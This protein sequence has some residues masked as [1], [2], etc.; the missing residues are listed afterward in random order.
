MCSR[1]CLIILLVARVNATSVASTAA[2]PSQPFLIP[3]DDSGTPH[4]S[5]SPPVQAQP[6]AQ[7][8]SQSIASLRK[9]IEPWVD[10]NIIAYAMFNADHPAASWST[11][12]VQDWLKRAGFESFLARLSDLDG[13]V[14]RVITYD[15]LKDSGVSPVSCMKI[16]M[17]RDELFAQEI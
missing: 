1:T 6:P 7:S 8:S 17:T 4:A 10:Q 15:V 9:G 14:L 16:L 11:S 13:S 2:P 12:Q 5:T 3:L